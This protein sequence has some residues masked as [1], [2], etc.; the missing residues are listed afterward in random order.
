M[1]LTQAIMSNILIMI[2]IEF[3]TIVVIVDGIILPVLYRK[4]LN[5]SPC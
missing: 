1:M 3:G 5:T 2:T 4:T